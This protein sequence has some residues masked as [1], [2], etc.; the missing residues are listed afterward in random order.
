M[1]EHIFFGVCVPNDN[2][3]DLVKGLTEESGEKI[4]I[5]DRRRGVH[6][7]RHGDSD[8]VIYVAGDKRLAF[9]IKDEF[10]VHNKTPLKASR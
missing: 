3:R 9:Y 7:P 2:V 5:A 8:L 10:A 4:Q 1:L 6:E